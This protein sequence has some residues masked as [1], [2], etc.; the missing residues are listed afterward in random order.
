M[1]GIDDR[2]WFAN[3]KNRFGLHVLYLGWY[4]VNKDQSNAWALEFKRNLS[5]IIYIVGKSKKIEVYNA[6]NLYIPKTLYFISNF[7]R[8]YLPSTHVKV[9]QE[10]VYK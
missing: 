7:S 5:E 1:R 6:F 8:M 10:I 9:L 3:Q 4:L 2:A